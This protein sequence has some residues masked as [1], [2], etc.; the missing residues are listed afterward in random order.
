[1]A[2]QRRYI[3]R[4]KEAKK[5]KSFYNPVNGNF[6]SEVSKLHKLGEKA[7]LIDAFRLCDTDSLYIC[8]MPKGTYIHKD[9]IYPRKLDLERIPEIELVN[10]Y[11]VKTHKVINKGSATI[12][13]GEKQF[14]LFP[15]GVWFDFPEGANL[16][17]AVVAL[18][19]LK[20]LLTEHFQPA[21]VHQGKHEKFPVEILATPAL[22]SMDLLRRKLPAKAR[23]ENL[24]PDIESI[25]MSNFSQART[26][27]FDHGRDIIE[28]LHN[29]DG[30]WFYAA[31]CRHVPTGRIIHDYENE[32]A[33][34]PPSKNGH[35][36][37][38]A[39]F[40]HVQVTVPDNWYHIGLL[41][42]RNLDKEKESAY[43]NQ[44]GE[45][46]ESWCS[47]KELRLAKDHGWH[48]E[49]LERILWP[50]TQT[51]KA[52]LGQ[53][54]YERTGQDPLRY[55][56]ESLVNL[57]QNVILKYPEPV[58]SMLKDAIRNLLNM[59][60]GKMH[61]ASQ[62]VDVYTKDFMEFPGK[63]AH[64]KDEYADRSM[65][66]EKKAELTPYQKQSFMPH[67]TLYVWCTCKVKI[68]QAALSVP[69]ENLV[70]IRTD[71]IWTTCPCEFE[72]TGKPGCF[73]EKQLENRGPFSWPKND[74]DFVL[75]IQSARGR[76]A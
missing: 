34:T 27:L 43:P 15:I 45:T 61:A 67:W 47:D 20:E 75:M 74:I 3:E 76:A 1:M 8:P 57:R 37:T 41:P 4:P 7:T 32:L 58:Q 46:F 51:R 56:M 28:R 26:E 5:T 70:S 64:L 22:T 25:L 50:D 59:G 12:K 73:R 54:A 52:D 42:I 31:C 49:I 68:T 6:Y 62:T 44:P 35:S 53:D 48:F 14:D 13:L 39:G 72:N 60:V 2:L 36:S 69:Y 38:I 30:L 33:M 23:Y 66:Y 63:G 71:G 65:R 40:Y 24:P 11:G 17:D 29:Y 9:S 21:I 10:F 18:G 16:S 19:R 55:W